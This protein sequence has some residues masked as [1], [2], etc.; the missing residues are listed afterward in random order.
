MRRSNPVLKAV[1][2]GNRLERTLWQPA[3]LDPDPGRHYGRALDGRRQSPFCRPN[4]LAR[5]TRPLEQL[6]EQN[7]RYQLTDAGALGWRF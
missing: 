2:P 6:T 3:A 7:S 1:G 4:A 5:A